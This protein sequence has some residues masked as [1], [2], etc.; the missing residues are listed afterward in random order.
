MNKMNITHCKTAQ[1][2][3]NLCDKNEQIK[4]LQTEVDMYK[5]AYDRLSKKE[6]FHAWMGILLVILS[7]AII[8][9]SAV[10]K[11]GCW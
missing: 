4:L 5:A 10:V 11:Y 9:L 3:A 2:A 8:I 1:M 7:I 6:E